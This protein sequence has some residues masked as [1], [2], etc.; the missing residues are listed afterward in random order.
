MDYNK[1]LSAK[2]RNESN[3]EQ[4][5]ATTKRI[6]IR[7]KKPLLIIGGIAAIALV[8]IASAPYLAVYQ[9]RQAVQAKDTEALEEH[10][11]F[12]RVRED[13]K[14]QVNASIMAKAKTELKDNPFAVLAT[15]FASGIAEKMISTLV[16]PTGLV[17][18]MKGEKPGKLISGSTGS[19]NNVTEPNK[20]PF[21][22]AR[23][24]YEGFSKFVIEVPDRN[25]GAP[26]QFILRRDL[27]AWRLTGIKIP[28]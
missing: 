1:A 7:Q 13:L 22:N 3:A 11:D 10:I 18:L 28:L 16:T 17:E 6:S 25:G 14:E 5:S 21:E 20:K 23:M 12:P 4:L 8:A 26:S 9:I 27:I 19:D 2:H 15:A 24:R